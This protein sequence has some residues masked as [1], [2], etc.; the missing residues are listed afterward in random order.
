M[1]PLIPN[2]YEAWRHCIEHR[3]NIPLTQTYIEE[4]LAALSNSYDVGGKHIYD[5][6]RIGSR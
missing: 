3:C 4:R 6:S 2:T 5:K 1:N